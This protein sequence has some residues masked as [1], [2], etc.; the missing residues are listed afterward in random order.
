M[1]WIYQIVQIYTTKIKKI[2]QNLI[3]L[4]MEI[5]I[6]LLE[7]ASELAHEIVCAKFEDDDN[8]IHMEDSDGI[9]YTEEAQEMFDEWYDHYYNLLLII[10]L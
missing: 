6:N 4:N 2:M 10:K 5:R 3:K 9:Y 8:L 1:K 7:A